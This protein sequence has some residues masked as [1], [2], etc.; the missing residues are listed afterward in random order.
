MKITKVE[1]R[2]FRSI[3]DEPLVFDVADGMNTLVGNNNGGKSNILRALALA[4]DPNQRIDRDH[5]LPGDSVHAVP[6][7]TLSIRCDKPTSVE[8]TLLRYADAYERN[9]K[10]PNGATHADDGMIRLVVSF[11]GRDTA[12]RRREEDLQ[13]LGRGAQHGDPKLR[14]KTLVQLRSCYR[15]VSVES[16]QSLASLLSGRFREILHTVLRDH[17]MHDMDV[18]D[19]RRSEY[20]ESLQDTLLRPLRD[21]V[22]SDVGKLFPEI[23]DVALIPR[24]STIDE[25]LSDVEINLRDLVAGTLGTKGTGVRG[26]VMVAM[27]RYLADNAKRSMVFAVEEPEAFL[28]PA[29]QEDLRDDLED[30][31]DHRDVTLFVSTHSP[32]VVSRR[33]AAQIISVAKQANGRTSITG[34]ARG[35]EPKASLLG[36]LFRDAALADVLERS[37]RIPAEARAVLITEGEG[38]IISLTLA[39]ERSGR[40]DLL[41]GLHLSAA[42]SAT[43]AVVHAIVTRSQTTKPIMVLFDNDDLGRKSAHLLTQS[44]GFQNRKEVMSYAELF[45]GQ[46]NI[47]AED[48]WPQRILAHFVKQFGEDSVISGKWQRHDGG[49][50]FDI[51]STA[52]DEMASFLLAEVA[53]PDCGRWV[54]LLELIRARLR[55]P[56][57]G[58]QNV[59]S[60]HH[61]QATSG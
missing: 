12:G 25:T 39:A 40:P 20:V 7:V 23:V 10:G 60:E 30:L 53:A 38:D 26:G 46:L 5:D 55:L 21:E 35:N 13:A 31:A 9:I 2:N 47:E 49:W 41:E 24:V 50:H 44:C 8:K 19:Q 51:R 54:E 34:S 1:I 61:Q 37:G 42:G 56:A 48:L 29:A 14:D 58:V 36:G 33:P 3:F 15:F 32:F 18:A 27:L 17:V 4:L 45:G 22:R 59:H 11:P 57:Q 43:K 16:G 52:K 28:H 6:R